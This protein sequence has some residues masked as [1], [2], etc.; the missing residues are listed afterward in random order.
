MKITRLNRDVMN[1]N[2]DRRK[3][4]LADGAD[5]VVGEGPQDAAHAELGGHQ[6]GRAQ[7]LRQADTLYVRARRSL[8]LGRIFW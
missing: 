8:R 1:R 7:R 3:R 6:A 2:G 4:D 5:V